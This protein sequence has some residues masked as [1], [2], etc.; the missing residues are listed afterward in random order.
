[1]GTLKSQEATVRRGEPEG[2]ELPG[3]TLR[4]FHPPTLQER[5]STSRQQYSLGTGGPLADMA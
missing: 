2:Q 1:M 3:T 5:S 4:P